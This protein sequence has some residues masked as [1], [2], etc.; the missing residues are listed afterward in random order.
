MR[1]A[2]AQEPLAYLEAVLNRVR[3]IPESHFTRYGGWGDRFS[4]APIDA[5]HSIFAKYIGTSGFDAA[6]A[7]TDLGID[8]ADDLRSWSGGVGNLPRDSSAFAQAKG[9]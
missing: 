7:F 2:P 1:S 4:L 9:A 8:S 5:V 3:L 6:T